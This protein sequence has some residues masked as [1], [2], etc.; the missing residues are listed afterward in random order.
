MKGVFKAV[1]VC[2]CE[3]RKSE[4]RQSRQKPFL[5]NGICKQNSLWHDPEH[6]SGCNNC[7][8]YKHVLPHFPSCTPKRC[9]Y[10]STN[11]PT[12][13]PSSPLLSCEAASTN[14]RCFK[15]PIHPGLPGQGCF[16]RTLPLS[17]Y[18]FTSM[19]QNQNLRVATI[20]TLKTTQQLIL[21]KTF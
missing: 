10:H 3:G 9:H 7:T 19:S 4:P 15:H 5:Q 2:T 13:F 17:R 16:N 12:I 6:P 8:R 20:T 14:Q 1:P 18:Q 21:P 11:T